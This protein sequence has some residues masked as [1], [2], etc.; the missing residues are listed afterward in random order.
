VLTT[1]GNPRSDGVA[2]G[3]RW[4]TATSDPV[5]DINAAIDAPGRRRDDQPD[6]VLARCLPRAPSNVGILDHFRPPTAPS[7]RTGHVALP[8]S[9][10][11]GGPAGDTANEGQA[12]S[13]PTCGQVVRHHRRLDDPARRSLA[14]GFTPGSKANAPRSVV[15]QVGR[16]QRWLL[17]QGRD[18]RDPQDHGVGPG[19]NCSQLIH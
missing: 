17:R 8:R 5:G 7:R 14:F 3:D 11:P 1:A 6:C 12:S 13:T 19:Y 2:G 4:D 10:V 15:R 18:E 16:H 9:T